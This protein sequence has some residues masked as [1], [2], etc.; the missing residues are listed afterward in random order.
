MNSLFPELYVLNQFHFNTIFNFLTGPVSNDDYYKYL[1]LFFGS[2]VGSVIGAFVVMY[3]K[4][5]EFEHLAANLNLQKQLFE[6]T[7]SNNELN[8]KAELVR[9]Q[10][11]SRQYQ[12]NLQQHDF[13]HLSKVLDFAG[14]SNEKVKMLKEFSKILENYRPKG[15]Y[16]YDEYEYQEFTVNHVFYKLDFIESSLDKLLQDYPNVFNTLHNDFKKV[17]M[18]AR[19]LISYSGEISSYNDEIDKEQIINELS[20]SLLNLNKSFYELLDK[21]KEEF[22]ELDTIKKKYIRSQFDNRVLEEKK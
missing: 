5:K 8:I 3:T 1:F 2:I 10:D 22:L 21:M 11:L 16:H 20:A 7:K 14:D 6:E 19:S 4:K 15:V 18:E 12:L 17:S 13:Q 9:L